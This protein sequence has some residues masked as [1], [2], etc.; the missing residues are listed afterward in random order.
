YC[1]YFY[2][3]TRSVVS[4]LLR[5]WVPSGFDD[6]VGEFI[7]LASSQ[8]PYLPSRGVLPNDFKADKT[9]F[10]LDDA[11]S[12]S[13]PFIYF[14]CGTMPRWEADIYARNLPPDQWN[15][16]WWKYVSDFQGVEPPSPRGE[17]F[18][19]AATKT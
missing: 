6:G 12:R 11:L 18:C 17:E 14:S 13:I 5:M 16:R 3:V 15:A 7:S 19:D 2:A 4:V 1:F 10:V 9:A 8:V